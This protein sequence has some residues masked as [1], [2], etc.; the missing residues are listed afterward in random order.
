MLHL[1]QYLLDIGAEILSVTGDD[2]AFVIKGDNYW[3]WGR[4]YVTYDMGNGIAISADQWR[5]M[6]WQNDNPLEIT[7][8]MGDGER[9]YFTTVSSEGKLN[10]VV[11]ELPE[12]KVEI[13]ANSF[14]EL[15][16]YHRE[17]GFEKTLSAE[18]YPNNTAIL[19]NIPQDPGEV[20][21]TTNTSE[22]SIPQ[23]Q[24]L[25]LTFIE[26]LDIPEVEMGEAFGALLVKGAPWG[27][28]NARMDS[29]GRNL[30]ARHAALPAGRA[31]ASQTG[32]GDTLLWLPAGYWDVEISGHWNRLV[33]VSTGKLTV[34]TAPANL[35][36]DRRAGFP[37]VLQRGA[38]SHACKGRYDC[39]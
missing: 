14:Y 1:E 20:Y 22:S 12:S 34:M 35:R 10:S 18:A 28:V 6:R 2:I 11:A 36:R 7:A 29:Y 24:R 23:G 27:S 16:D 4:V 9:L 31:I 15:G 37:V 13:S 17:V 25:I 5:E 19:D 26:T 38:Q 21:W 3:W 33:P 39:I 30:R 32:E 8:G